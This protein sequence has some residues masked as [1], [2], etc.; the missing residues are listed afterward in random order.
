MSLAHPFVRD[1][2]HFI[3]HIAGPSASAS[4]GPKDGTLT[5]TASTSRI[6]NQ[7]SR[8]TGRHVALLL[9]L[10]PRGLGPYPLP[11]RVASIPLDGNWIRTARSDMT[12]LRGPSIP[13]NT[14][15]LT[16]PQQSS[17]HPQRIKRRLRD[18]HIHPLTRTFLW[19]PSP[20][21]GVLT[22]R[23]LPLR[24][25]PRRGHS[26]QKAIKLWGHYP[27]INFSF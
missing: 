21:S 4:L 3:F 19:D 12:R 5:V 15:P 17:T 1:I 9:S 27:W 24:R 7:C 18:A 23:P 10:S 8:I 13:S 22:H 20:S 25:N 6:N 16:P 14:Y 26:Q 11:I 2:F